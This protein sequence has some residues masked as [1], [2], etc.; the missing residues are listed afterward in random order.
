M[1]TII[2]KTEMNEPDEWREEAMLSHP[3][4]QQRVALARQSAREGKGISIEQ[5]RAEL[6][7]DT[8]VVLALPESSEEEGVALL[9][10]DREYP[11]WTPLNAFGVAGTLMK[12]L[13]NH[14]A[15]NV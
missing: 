3:L 15:A 14:R 7:I 8:L 12:M 6:E 5:L 13:E 10:T 2:E 9:A 1:A 4:F 11:I